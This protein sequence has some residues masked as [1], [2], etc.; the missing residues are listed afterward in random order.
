VK[1]FFKLYKNVFALCINGITIG[2]CC[3][4]FDNLRAFLTH[5]EYNLPVWLIWGIPSITAFSV[6]VLVFSIY[7][8]YIVYKN[9]TQFLSPLDSFSDAILRLAKQFN[10]EGRDK[11]LVDLR[12]N[13]SH[14]LHI[15]GYHKIREELGKLAL[16]SAAVV[17]DNE[18]KVEVL[19][20]DLGWC[21]FMQGENEHAILNIEQAIEV[22]DT[23]IR[24][25]TNIDFVR[26]NLFKAKA[27]RHLATI[28]SISNDIKKSDNLLDEAYNIISKL[29]K[30]DIR[31]A[32][33]VAQIS[34]CKAQNV[35]IRYNISETGSIRKTD[36]EAL[37]AIH[38]ATCFLTEAEKKFSDVGDIDRKVKSLV[39]HARLLESINDE[40][41]YLEIAA[42]K[43]RAIASS[44]WLNTN[45]I[46]KVSNLKGV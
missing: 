1:N 20:D 29:D 36:K 15:F 6:F 34:F 46:I 43:N 21:L 32:T 17:K 19:C 25:C 26:V 16:Q 44:Q 27:L 4:I 23:I 24:D 37:N 30:K 35:A 22:A 12:N 3:F 42:L 9:R 11:P 5:S 39:L 10:K 28:S 40:S 8:V 33:D 13:T 14:T 45:N 7:T 41:R 18:T 2:L 31:V 38:E